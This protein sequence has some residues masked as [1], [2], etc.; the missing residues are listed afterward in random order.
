MPFEGVNSQQNGNY[1]NLEMEA[2]DDEY[3]EEISEFSEDTE[4]ES[5]FKSGMQKNLYLDED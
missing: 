3:N 1:D 5:L 2:L 4:E